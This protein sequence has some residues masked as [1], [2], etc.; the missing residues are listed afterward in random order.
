MPESGWKAN[1]SGVVGAHNIWNDGTNNGIALGQYEDGDV[2]NAVV[3]R[4]STA[5][6]TS[7][8]HPKLKADQILINQLNTI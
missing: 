8:E 3:F 4:N 7:F 5:N 6:L 1:Y 2:G